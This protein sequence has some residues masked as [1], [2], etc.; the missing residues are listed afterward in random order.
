MCGV[1][2][3]AC[4]CNVCVCAQSKEEDAAPEE[5]AGG[6]SRAGYLFL[7]EKSESLHTHWSP[8]TP[9]PAAECHLSATSA[10]ERVDDSMYENDT[11]TCQT[12]R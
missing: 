7:M 12:L 1:C 8:T 10:T 11:N 9:Q 3:C 2:V 6:V 4:V 5:A